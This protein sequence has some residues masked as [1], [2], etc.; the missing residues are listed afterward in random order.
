[1]REAWTA[2]VGR[3]SLASYGR[4]DVALRAINAALDTP[5]AYEVSVK[6]V[7][8]GPPSPPVSIEVDGKLAK[9]IAGEQFFKKVLNSLYAGARVAGFSIRKLGFIDQILEAK[10]K[11]YSLYWL[12]ENGRNIR[13]AEICSPAL[14]MLGDHKGFSIQ[15]EKML[16]KMKVPRISLGPLPYFTSHCITIVSEELIRRGILDC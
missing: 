16:K 2:N 10:N 13:G 9:P 11:G 12:E 5:V 15:A 3:G 4:L 1:M 7:L 14:F 6:L 8:E